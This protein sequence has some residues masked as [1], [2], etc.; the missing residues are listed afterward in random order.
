MAR[1]NPV[2]AVDSQGLIEK[3]RWKSRLSLLL[4][5]LIG[6]FFI[7]YGT[8]SLPYVNDNFYEYKFVKKTKSFFKELGVAFVIG[9]ILSATVEHYNRRRHIKLAEDITNRVADSAVRQG[10]LALF[11]ALSTTI[12]GATQ[13][14]ILEAAITRE[15]YQIS[16]EF[17]LQQGSVLVT[18]TVR[19]KM[20]NPSEA[21]RET[22][23][24]FR[25]EPELQGGLPRE[26]CPT[27]L[28][29]GSDEFDADGLESAKLIVRD[30][31][32]VT[33]IRMPNIVVPGKSA[34][35]AVL[36]FTEKRGLD[37]CIY[38][39]MTIPSDGLSLMVTPCIGLVYSVDSLHPD[40]A[41]P[42]AS[43][44]LSKVKIWEIAG[45]LLPGQGILL[46]WRCNS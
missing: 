26:A 35:D 5:A 17:E 24:S 1:K 27:Y 39:I 41:E 29:I 43:A 40:E 13:K 19:Y 30:P 42:E 36:Q 14:H 8:G 12:M 9:W 46:R 28:K 10:V 37:D 25:F 6:V 33:E 18:T 32:R 15:K 20:R 11:P 7:A 31:V 38:W 34:V 44:K 45:G 16:A 2:K 3:E 22:H 23:F 4:I 21:A